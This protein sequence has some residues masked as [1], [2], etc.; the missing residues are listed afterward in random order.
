MTWI[1]LNAPYYPTYA[2][3]YPDNL[4]G[5]APLDDK[6]LAR[7][8]ELTGVPLSQ[9]AGHANNRGPQVSFDRPELS[10]CLAK[11]SDKADPQYQEAL[12][13][14]RAGT[15]SLS[16]RPEADAPGFR[17][18]P[19]DEWRDAKYLARQQREQQNRDAL[20]VGAKRFEGGNRRLLPD[21][22][23]PGSSR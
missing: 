7:L 12:A 23:E 13:L 22:G 6:Q 20:R 15:E 14:I 16:R 11:F 5:R 17:P 21:T 18:N 9:L 1:D 2:S 3:A 19:T 4:G 10:P 8:E